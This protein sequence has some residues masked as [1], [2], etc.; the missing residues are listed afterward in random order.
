LEHF[1][2]CLDNDLFP[3]AYAHLHILYMTFVCIQILRISKEKENEF[4]LCWIGFPSDEKAFLK[5]PTTPFVFGGISEKSIFRFFRLLSFDD[6][7]I[8]NISN[9]VKVRNERLHAKGEIFFKDRDD[10]EKEFNEYIKRM[11]QIVKK[12]KS[13]LEEIYN[14]LA[15]DFPSGNEVTQDYIETDYSIQY[16]FSQYELKFLAESKIDIVSKYIQEG[17]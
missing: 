5:N 6:G 15:S 11:D 12:Q 13:F 14:Q 4:N 16:F 17:L 2:K 10:F 3:S 1:G 7:T 9:P 8:G